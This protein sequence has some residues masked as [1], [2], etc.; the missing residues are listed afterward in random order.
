M[1]EVVSYRREGRIALITVDNP[2]VNAL[3][4]PVRAGLAKA[5]TQFAADGDAAAAVLIC[6]G[7]TFIAGADITEFDK[8]IEEPWLPKVIHQIE[9]SK[10]PVVAAIHGY[11]LGA[12]L[13]LAML[14]DIRIAATD[15]I[16]ALAQVTLGTQIVGGA[17]LRMV[18]ELGAARVK[19]L[20][21]TGRRFGPAEAEQWGLVQQVVA[22]DELLSTA[23][24]LAHEIAGN[25]PLAVQGVKRAVNHV[26]Y[27]GFDEASS[28]EAL[29]SSVLWSSDDVYKGFA[30]KARKE[31]ADFDG[32]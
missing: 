16:F 15:A 23:M 17:D 28:F 22:P 26:A 19:W 1:A 3:S 20:A 12:G 2:P 30:A 21:M 5:F 27:R 31:Q 13:E 11:C 10:K 8:P 7:R 14:A 25:A 29:A 18:S 32:K 9:D 6:A 24:A 4:L